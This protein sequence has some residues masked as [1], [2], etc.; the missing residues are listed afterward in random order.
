MVA[1]VMALT[2]GVIPRLFIP[3]KAWL[4]VTGWLVWLIGMSALVGW[5]DATG[6]GVGT[7]LCG[8]PA[9]LWLGDAW[10]EFRERRHAEPVRSW[11]V[12]GRGF[13]SSASASDVAYGELYVLDGSHFRKS[14]H[15][16]LVVCH[17]AARLDVAGDVH[18]GVMCHYSPNAE[19][20]ESWRVLVNPV[21]ESEEGVEVRAGRL[22]EINYVPRCWV[23]DVS[24]AG[25][26]LGAFLGGD[27]LSAD[28]LEWAG[29]SQAA[30]VRLKA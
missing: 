1:L 15:P 16:R 10:M 28:G 21:M 14:E 12:N 26:A 24:H 8:M 22:G 7:W 20:E 30:V 5:S 23:N 19:D 17:G 27:P 6:L 13:D 25:R 2:V 4:V 3:A 29:G 9:G 11:M 18:D